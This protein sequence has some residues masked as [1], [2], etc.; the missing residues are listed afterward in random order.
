M[1]KT[2]NPLKRRDRKLDD[3]VKDGATI[4]NL[5]TKIKYSPHHDRGDLKVLLHSLCVEYE[6][7]HGERYTYSKFQLI[8]K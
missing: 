1:I 7:K 5:V 3:K 6:E 2:Y 4:H 8:K